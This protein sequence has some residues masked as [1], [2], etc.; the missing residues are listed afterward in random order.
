MDIT[1]E[2]SLFSAFMVVIGLLVY[3]IVLDVYIHILAII[4]L[5]V[6]Y[7]FISKRYVKKL[8][9]T[10]KGLFITGCDTGMS[11]C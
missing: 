6:I 3:L 2:T 10:E 9:I 5:Y 4:A 11:A 7:K 8:D 1:S